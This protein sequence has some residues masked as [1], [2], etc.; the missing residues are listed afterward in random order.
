MKPHLLNVPN[1]KPHLLN[2]PNLPDASFRYRQ[3]KQSNINNCWHYHPEIELGRIHQGFG[4]QFMGDSIRRFHAGDII[5]VGSNLPH[6][7][8]YDE[9]DIMEENSLYSTVIHFTENLWGDHFFE[10]PENNLI[11]TII[12]KSKRGILLTGKTR[13]VVTNLIEKINYSQGTYRLIHLLECLVAISLG[14]QDEVIPLASLGFEHQTS[15]SEQERINA[16]YEY[17]FQNFKERIPLETIAS[18]VG[19]EIGRA[20]V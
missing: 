15:I 11:K 12:E 2:V 3:F 16:I 17:S 18:E 4:T 7:W 19:L 5:L 1:M 20:H 9:D 13:N 8:R 10:L 6:F 14:N